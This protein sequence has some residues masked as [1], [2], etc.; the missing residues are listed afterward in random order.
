MLK[1]SGEGDKTDLKIADPC[2][3]SKYEHIATETPAE[4]REAPGFKRGGGRRDKGGANTVTCR[5]ETERASDRSRTCD[6][7]LSLSSFGPMGA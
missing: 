4:I 7:K 1:R 5:R 2:D 3:G 6:T